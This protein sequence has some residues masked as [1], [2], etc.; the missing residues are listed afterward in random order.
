[1]KHL[2][3]LL[4]ILVA[5]SLLAPSLTADS[6]E[7]SGSPAFSSG[8]A[9]GEDAGDVGGDAVSAPARRTDEKKR[10]PK[11]DKEKKKGDQDKDKDDDDDDDC[12]TDCLGIILEGMIADICS[13]DE[14]KTDEVQ[15]IQDPYAE[16]FVAFTGMIVPMD[17][18]AEDIALWDM[19]GGEDLNAQVVAR[20]PK[21]TTLEVIERRFVADVLW[22][23]VEDARAPV[24]TGWVTAQEIAEESTLEP[25][26]DEE[27]SELAPEPIE[28]PELVSGEG[29]SLSLGTPVWQVLIDIGGGLPNDEYFSGEK[30]IRDDY[31]VLGFRYGARLRVSPTD[32]LQIGF[33]VVHTRADGDPQCNYKIFHSQGDTDSTRDIPTDS[34]LEILALEL[35]LGAYI[36]IG[37]R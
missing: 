17:P 1:M 4:V 25:E 24:T 13:D 36:P 35:Q 19:P 33:G 12:M 37:G 27:G 32:M 8:T 30:G 26:I 29:P 15:L 11:P 34:N 7:R 10:V 18:A 20:I 16:G 31:K 28:E 21:G 23:R 22:F 2:L 6:T 14:E 9:T 5:L 3:A